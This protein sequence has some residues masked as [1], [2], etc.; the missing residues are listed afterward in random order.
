MTA[1]PMYELRKENF[2]LREWNEDL[3]TELNR[4]RNERDE[5]LAALTGAHRFIS[6]PRRMTPDEISYDPRPYNKLT[7]ALRAAIAKPGNR[8]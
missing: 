2:K 4:T 1:N 8:S 7:A 5:L 3:L 6:Q